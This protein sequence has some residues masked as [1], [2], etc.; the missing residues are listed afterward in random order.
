MEKGEKSKMNPIKTVT[1]S[2]SVCD[3]KYAQT[4]GRYFPSTSY[5]YAAF[6]HG[7][8]LGRYENGV[9]TIRFGKEEMQSNE[10]VRYPLEKFPWEYLQEV[11]LFDETRE[12]RLRRDGSRFA[13]RVIQDDL[14]D[15][16][17]G[18]VENI[19]RD[20]VKDTKKEAGNDTWK[21][22]VYCT[23]EVQKLWGEVK[24]SDQGWC[25]L[26]SKRG[27]RIWVPV[28]FNV[29]RNDK[30]LGIRVRKYFSFPDLIQELGFCNGGDNNSGFDGIKEMV[31]YQ[32]ERFVELCWWPQEGVVR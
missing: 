32:D 24:H 25:L 9:F 12:V 5:V 21:E 30:W 22:P 23:D 17:D 18:S 26:E 4:A 31:H 15:K 19:E 27:T 20:T 16:V 7:V 14:N 28:D 11:R 13:G 10:E 2:F 29:S 3:K 8:A 6:Y 1:E